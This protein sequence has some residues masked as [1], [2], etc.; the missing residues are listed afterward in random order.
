MRRGR[1]QARG[2]LAAAVLAGCGATLTDAGS[3]AVE[4][5]RLVVECGALEP[6]VGDRAVLH[7]R[8][9]CMRA[10][11]RAGAARSVQLALTYR[12]PTERAEPLGSGE[13]RRQ[14]G[15]KLRARD[16]CN[17]VYAMWHVE[18]RGGLHVSVKSNPGKSRHAECRDGGYLNVRPRFVREVPP[19][20]P[21]ARRTLAATLEGRVLTVRVDGIRS[22][23]GE[24]PDEAL[25][26]DGPAGFRS[27]NGVFDVELSTSPGDA[28]EPAPAPG[29]AAAR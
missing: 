25:R 10:V 9:P 23:E 6:S 26:F 14:I 1:G 2:A 12:G 27:D 22:W 5:S 16:T 8:T 11:L 7:V 28:R 24:L 18:P 15:L 20:V 19:L 13:L 29:G 17:V 4:P 21:G 3:R